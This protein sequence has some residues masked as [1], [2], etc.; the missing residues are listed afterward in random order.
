MLLLVFLIELKGIESK[1]S[2][3]K[4]MN[5]VFMIKFTVF[6]KTHNKNSNKFS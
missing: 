3:T 4:P 6:V 2:I 5:W 1:N